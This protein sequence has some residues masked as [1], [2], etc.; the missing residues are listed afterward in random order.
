[1]LALLPPCSCCHTVTERCLV[2]IAS[3]KDVEVDDDGSS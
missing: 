1:M 2:D 3:P